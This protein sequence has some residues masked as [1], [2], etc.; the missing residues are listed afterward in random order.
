MALLLSLILL[1]LSG[2]TQADGPGTRIRSGSQIPQP[3][4]FIQ[5]DVQKDVA[6]RK[7]VEKVTPKAASAAATGGTPIAT[8][9]RSP[10][11]QP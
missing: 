9:R 7:E 5:K 1:T 2:P 6:R 10:N 11:P 8:E 3:A 4:G